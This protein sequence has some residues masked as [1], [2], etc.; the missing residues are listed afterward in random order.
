MKG[1]SIGVA[2]DEIHKNRLDLEKRS[3]LIKAGAHIIIG[4][5]NQTGELLNL[6][7]T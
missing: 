1:V 5:F 7:S 3:R 6:L 2:S 4:D